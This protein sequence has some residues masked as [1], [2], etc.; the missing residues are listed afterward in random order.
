MAEKV[1]LIKMQNMYISKIQN[2]VK[3]ILKSKKMLDEFNSIINNQIGGTS[4]TNADIL[5]RLS[6]QGEKYNSLF[7]KINTMSINAP[8][9]NSALL[10]RYKETQEILEKQI[11]ILIT[12]IQ[13]LNSSTNCTDL[14]DKHTKAL[15]E[16]AQLKKEIAKFEGQINNL[17][18][19]IDKYKIMEQ[20][21]TDIKT[22]ADQHLTNFE[23][24]MNQ[25]TDFVGRYNTNTKS[26]L[27]A[28]FNS[29]KQFITDIL[30][31]IEEVTN[32]SI[33]KQIQDKYNSEQ[34]D[35]IKTEIEVAAT[36]QDV[37]VLDKS[38]TR[39]N[40]LLDGKPKEFYTN[41]KLIKLY[42]E[43]KSNMPVNESDY[44]EAKIYFNI[45]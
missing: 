29:H 24:Y 20:E 31:T 44:T 10:N 15:Q 3:K 42:Y 14:L 39:I 23:I 41:L 18:A 6:S 30:K 8:N 22:A 17:T 12:Q 13:Q 1:N 4:P 16:I 11:S 45:Q 34:I 28:S 5:T 33:K 35:D 38:N 43:V 40:Q 21:C 25:V 19:E 32:A 27:D 26:V 2:Y 9:T 7:S 37:I 36:E